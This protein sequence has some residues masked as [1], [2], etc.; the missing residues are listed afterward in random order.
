M[1][2]ELISELVLAMEFM[3]SAEDIQRTIHA[4]PSLAE[5]VHEASLAVDKKMLHG[6]NR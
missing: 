1:A 6:I 4:H 2:G 3:A 5:A